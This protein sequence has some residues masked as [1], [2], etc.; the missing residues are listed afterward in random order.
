MV[1][2]SALLAICAGNSPVT[3]EFPAQRPV[4]RSFDVYFDLHLNKQLSKQLWGWW[5]ETHSWSLWRHCN[6]I[7]LGH[8][9]FRSYLDAKQVTNHQLNQRGLINWILGNKLQWNLN[10]KGNVS[11]E[12]MPFKMSAKWGPFCL[13]LILYLPLCFHHVPSNL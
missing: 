3:G 10:P 7:E 4:T 8:H 5:F 12:K 11:V 13:G 6:V 1:I 2:F 9:W